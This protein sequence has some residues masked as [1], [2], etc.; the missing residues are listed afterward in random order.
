ME[1]YTTAV[2]ALFDAD[3]SKADLISSEVSGPNSITLRWRL[4]GKLKIG[5][6]RSTIHAKQQKHSSTA[7][8]CQLCVLLAH[9]T[10]KVLL[11]AAVCWCL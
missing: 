6:H 1:P 5:E 10:A 2:A 8:G 7:S 4:E 11:S 9:L 3:V